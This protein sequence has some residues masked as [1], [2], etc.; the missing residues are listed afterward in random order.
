MTAARFTRCDL[1]EQFQQF[2]AHA[3]LPRYKAGG[4]A[5]WPCQA[6]NDPAADRVDGGYKHRFGGLEIDHKLIFR[7]RL[8]RQ[9]DRLLALEDAIDLG[10]SATELVN[11]IGTVGHPP[12]SGSFQMRPVYGLAL[13][14]F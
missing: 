4:V 5:A 1:F 3:E 13:R 9:V 11:K 2:P 6:R 14:V 10:A 12:S 7:R 8:H